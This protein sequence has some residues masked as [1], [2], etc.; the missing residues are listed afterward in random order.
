MRGWAGDLG[1]QFRR[2]IA[3]HGPMPV[4]RFMGESNAHY[5]AT[6]DP[7]GLSSGADG[8]DFV[9]APEISQMFGELCGLWLADVW[10]RAGGPTDPIYA[11]LGPGRGTLARDVLRAMAG[12]G[13]RPEVHLVEGSPVLRG[14]QGAAVPGARFHEDAASLPDDRPLLILANEFLDALPIRQLVRT[15][16]G[17]RERLVGLREDSFVF[18]AGDQPMDE[19]IPDRFDGA[20]EGTVVETCPGATAAIRHLAERLSRQGGAMLLIDY[21]HLDPQSGS[22]LQAVR[23]HRKVS[24]FAAPGEADLT[25]HVDFATLAQ[26]AERNGCHVQTATQG[27]WL[28]EMGIEL[29]AAALAKSAPEQSEDLALACNRLVHAD[30]MGKLF[31]VLAV[32][33]PD[34]PAGAG[35]TSS[36]G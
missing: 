17:W 22:T 29:R 4:A 33:A 28:R 31:K 18:V 32:I 16:R 1:A 30:E 36:G 13:L 3:T 34:W 23:A 14:L 19:A 20:S 21:G 5:Y 6:R 7:L 9:T 27:D 10:M 26:I 2:L 11:E 8:G 35:F 12:A 24:P 15:D 25:A